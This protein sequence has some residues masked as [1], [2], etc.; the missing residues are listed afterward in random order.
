MDDHEDFVCGVKIYKITRQ[1]CG[2]WRCNNEDF[3]KQFGRFDDD[4]VSKEDEDEEDG[5]KEEQDQ[6]GEYVR[7]GPISGGYF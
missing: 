1:L 6:E 7:P 3:V 2:K 5:N 4:E